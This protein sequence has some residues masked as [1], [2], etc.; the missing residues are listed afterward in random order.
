MILCFFW[1]VLVNEDNVGALL[2]FKGMQEGNFVRTSDVINGFLLK[3]WEKLMKAL[4][5]DTLKVEKQKK[6][7]FK[8][9]GMLL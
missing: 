6:E 4:I 5:L 1:V 2:Q 9:K 3:H 7:G 8:I